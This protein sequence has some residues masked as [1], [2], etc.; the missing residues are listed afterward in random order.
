MK[1]AFERRAHRN[2]VQRKLN[3]DKVDV[4]HFVESDVDVNM[5]SSIQTY[6]KGRHR[7]QC[8][9]FKDNDGSKSNTSADTVRPISVTITL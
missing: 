9:S 5:N 3:E 6:Y 2:E 4:L 8:C 7:C 1:I